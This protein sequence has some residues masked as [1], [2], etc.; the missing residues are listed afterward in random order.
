MS[1]V[2]YT[3]R[4]EGSRTIVHRLG[5]AGTMSVRPSRTGKF[6]DGPP[7]DMPRSGAKPRGTD[8]RRSSGKPRSKDEPRGPD[9]R[10]KRKKGK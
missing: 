10:A 4:T 7:G 8:K 3:V 5:K 1:K 2:R 9:K 6:V